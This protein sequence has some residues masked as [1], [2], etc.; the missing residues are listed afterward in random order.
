MA[1]LGPLLQQPKTVDWRTPECVLERVRRVAPIRLD[2]CAS[3]NGSIGAQEEWHEGGL[4]REWPRDGLIYVNPPY[5]RALLPWMRKCWREKT[6][7]VNIIALVPA[8]TDTK[9]WQLYAAF[10]QHHCFWRGRLTFVGGQHPAPFPSVILSWNNDRQKFSTA[11][12][13]AE[14]LLCR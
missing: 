13:D 3:R 7:G 14:W 2:P 10:A 8:R 1:N 9:W 11:F 6:R 5:S 12:L 4:D